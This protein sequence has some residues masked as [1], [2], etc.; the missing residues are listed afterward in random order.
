MQN[1]NP[2]NAVE[3]GSMHH[4][5]RGKQL[6]ASRGS[7][8]RVLQQQQEIENELRQIPRHT[9]EQVREKTQRSLALLADREAEKLLK[10]G[11]ERSEKLIELL[12]CLLARSEE[13]RRWEG[14][15]LR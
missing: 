1:Q 4:K 8:K 15:R 11:R 6:H 12:R 10:M 3:N 2:L 13:T 9:S 5:S 7:Q 14:N